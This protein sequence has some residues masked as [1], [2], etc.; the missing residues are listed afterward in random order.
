MRSKAKKI[1]K[2]LVS[3]DIRVLTECWNSLIGVYL[4]YGQVIWGRPSAYALD[5]LQALQKR[6][7]SGAQPCNSCRAQK[8][9]KEKGDFSPCRKHLGPGEM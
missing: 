1:R 8:L 5:R 2:C 9:K 6:F 3:R 7:L 4:N